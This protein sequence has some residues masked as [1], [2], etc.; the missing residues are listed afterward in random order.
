MSKSLV[1][2]IKVISL[3]LDGTLLDSN[4]RISV[5]NEMVLQWMHEQGKTIVVATGSPYELIPWE[6]LKNIQIDYVITANGSAVYENNSGRC[7][8]EKTISNSESIEI[9]RKLERHDVH[10][11]CFIGGKGYTTPECIERITRLR[12]SDSRKT[13]LRNHR[14]IVE[15]LVTTVE[16]DGMEIQKITLNFCADA[17]GNLVDYEELKRSLL[18]C[19][20]IVVTTGVKD[21]LEITGT[22]V[23][24]GVALQKLAEILE[25]STENIVA[26]GDSMNDKA[27]IEAAGI[28][29][30][31]GNAMGRLKEI[32]NDVTVSNDDDGVAVWLE[33][34][35]K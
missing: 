16:G 13:Y 32:A 26:F 21:N 10:I 29:V 12:A 28:G 20:G 7:L 14:H 30:A 9:L 3:D 6:E 22:G 15:N 4:R 31:M 18:S 2:D 23:D 27:I 25:I 35:M 11:D 19:P 34:W 33:R 17:E 5:K 8:Y 24:K 1:R